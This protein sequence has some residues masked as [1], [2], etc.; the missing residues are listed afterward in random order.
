MQIRHPSTSGLSDQ[1]I[2]DLTAYS[3]SFVSIFSLYD[4]QQELLQA[5]H[6]QLLKTEVVGLNPRVCFSV[7]DRAFSESVCVFF[8][9]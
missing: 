9:T 6:L 1:V 8:L 7:L 4:G 2:L 3:S 5:A